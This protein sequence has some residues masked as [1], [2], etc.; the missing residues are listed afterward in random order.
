MSNF[1][2]L[3]TNRDSGMILSRTNVLCVWTWISELVNLGG[4]CV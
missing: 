1:E 4:K 2:S 3:L